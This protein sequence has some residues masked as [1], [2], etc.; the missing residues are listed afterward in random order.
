MSKKKIVQKGQRRMTRSSVLGRVVR[1][2]LS[3]R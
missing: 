3:M 1:K 2:G